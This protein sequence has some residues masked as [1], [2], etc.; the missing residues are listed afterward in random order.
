MY[1]YQPGYFKGFFL[2]IKILQQATTTHC[3]SI[4]I[5]LNL[6]QNRKSQAKLW[7]WYWKGQIFL[8][9]LSDAHLHNIPKWTFSAPGGSAARACQE[10]CSQ[11]EEVLWMQLP[12]LPLEWLTIAS[13]KNEQV[14]AIGLMQTAHWKHLKNF[15]PTSCA[16]TINGK[17]LELSP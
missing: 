3:V 9:L 1:V 12:S 4:H 17:K 15:N 13:W 8:A 10:S 11:A 6:M 14:M 2:E 5:T 16:G 7:K